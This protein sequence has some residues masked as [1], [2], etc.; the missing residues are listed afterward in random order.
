MQTTDRFKF[1]MTTSI[2][3]W[4]CID[5]M[6]EADVRLELKEA[7]VR[8]EVLEKDLRKQ[9]AESRQ[10]KAQVKQL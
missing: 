3:D 10:L 2:N 4:Q 8:F 9:L 7:R 5:S 6:T 1:K